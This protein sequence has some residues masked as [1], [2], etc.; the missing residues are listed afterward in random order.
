[1]TMAEFATGFVRYAINHSGLPM[2][3]AFYYYTWDLSALVGGALTTFRCFS[4]ELDEIPEE[5][6]SFVERNLDLLDG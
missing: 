1:M 3:Q 2:C 5:L 6:W 4:Y